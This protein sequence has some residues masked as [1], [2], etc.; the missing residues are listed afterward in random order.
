MTDLKPSPDKWQSTISL[1]SL[2][3][4]G[5]WRTE[6]QIFFERR[7]IELFVGEV[8]CFAQKIINNSRKYLMLK[9]I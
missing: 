9:I 5:A 8:N 7:H 1:Y 6:A 3:L 4:K 2:V